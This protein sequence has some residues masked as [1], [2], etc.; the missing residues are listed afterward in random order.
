MARLRTLLVGDDAQAWEDVGFTVVDSRVML[1]R[2]VLELVGSADGRGILGWSLPGIDGAVDGLLCSPVRSETP[3]PGQ[4][5]RHDNGVFSIDH[6]EISTDDVDRSVVAFAD[7]GMAEQRRV[8]SHD[9]P[10][11]HRVR[12]YAGRTV[13]ELVGP[14]PDPKD[15]GRAWFTGL[16]LVSDDLDRTGELLGDLL[17]TPQDVDDGRRAA[18]LRSEGSDISVPITILSPHPT[19]GI[20]QIAADERESQI[21]EL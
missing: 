1:G 7:A 17:T 5:A 10:S 8:T 16:G 12:F 11:L 21:I 20:E 15:L 13:L 9:A 2:V 18:T 14:R 3:K 6:V 19:A 4:R